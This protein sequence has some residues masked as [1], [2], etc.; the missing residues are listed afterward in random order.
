LFVSV[1]TKS[2]TVVVKDW[3]VRSEYFWQQSGLG[4]THHRFFAGLAAPEKEAIRFFVMSVHV[5]EDTDTYFS[6]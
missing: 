6:L 1:F 4:P 2:A 3:L 5:T